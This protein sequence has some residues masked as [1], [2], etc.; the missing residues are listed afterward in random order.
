MPLSVP[1]VTSMVPPAMVPV[2]AIDTV[3]RLRKSVSVRSRVPATLKVAPVSLTIRVPI[4]KVSLLAMVTV[5]VPGSEMV[6]TRSGTV[7]GFQFAAVPQ[8]PPLAEVQKLPTSAGG[9]PMLMRV[10]PTPSE[11]TSKSVLPA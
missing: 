10:P 11:E 4:L 2:D 8:S 9:G 5:Y 6:A 3:P 7:A 1:P